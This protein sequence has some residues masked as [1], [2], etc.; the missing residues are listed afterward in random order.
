MGMFDYVNYNCECPVCGTQV[1]DFQS[2]DGDCLLERVEPTDVSYF[3]ASCRGCGAWISFSR[4]E[5]NMYE[6]VVTVKDNT[7][8]FDLTPIISE[9]KIENPEANDLFF[10]LDTLHYSMSET[11]ANEDRTFYKQANEALGILSQLLHKKGYRR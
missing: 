11:C 8:A 2:K 3:Y 4:K 6:R 10:V 1:T 7:K 5:Y 9:I